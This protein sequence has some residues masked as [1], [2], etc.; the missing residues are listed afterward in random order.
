MLYFHGL[1]K[2]KEYKIMITRLQ[3]AIYFF[4]IIIMEGK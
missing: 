2:I 3:K 4:Y 1:C